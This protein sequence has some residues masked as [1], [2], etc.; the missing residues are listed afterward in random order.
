M[1]QAE[2]LWVLQKE[3]ALVTCACIKGPAIGIGGFESLCLWLIPAA[4]FLQGSW[5]TFLFSQ[6]VH[7]AMGRSSV[8]MRHNNTV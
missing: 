3:T 8:L 5:S 1:L 2:L 6:E 7:S 4:S